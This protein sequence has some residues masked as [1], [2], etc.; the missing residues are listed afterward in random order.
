MSFYHVPDNLKVDASNK[1]ILLKELC[2]KML[3]N[4]FPVDKKMGFPNSSK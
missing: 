3:P 1:K 4:N 2:K